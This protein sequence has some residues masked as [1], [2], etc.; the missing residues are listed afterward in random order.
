MYLNYNMS[1]TDAIGKKGSQ[2]IETY[3]KKLPETVEVINVED[4]VYYRNKDIDLIWKRNIGSQIIGTKIEVKTDR[5]AR[6]G[7]YFLETISNESKNTSGCFLYTEADFVYYYFIETK[8]LHILPMPESRDWF[9]LNMERFKE[10]RT[11]TPVENGSY[12]TVGRLVPRYIMQKEVQ[13]I[14]IVN[15]LCLMQNHF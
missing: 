8:E 2:D 6:S 11:S 5:Y 7:N 14:K 4:D 3:L 9:I 15:L 13:N 1:E 12:C 10:R